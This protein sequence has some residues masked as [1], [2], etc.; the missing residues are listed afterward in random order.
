M[1]IC[2][3]NDGEKIF[4]GAVSKSLLYNIN[5]GDNIF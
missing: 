4:F 5:D 3:E 2:S 1:Y